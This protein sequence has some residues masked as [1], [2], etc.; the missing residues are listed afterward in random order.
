[1]IKL[2]VELNR[3]AR[4]KQEQKKQVVLTNLQ[5]WK[6]ETSTKLKHNQEAIVVN[7]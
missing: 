4:T 5:K 1:M 2:K 6:K 7:L 3:F